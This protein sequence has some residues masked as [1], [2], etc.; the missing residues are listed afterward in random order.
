MIES[1]TAAERL[2]AVLQG[3][4]PDRVPFLLPVILQGARALG[5]TIRDYL[6]S[7]EAVIEG[8][9]RLQQRYGHDGVFGFLHAS[10]EVEAFGGTTLF[11]DDGPPNAGAPPLRSA[12]DLD[13]LQP[14]AIERCPTLQRVL[15]ILVGLR[16]RVGGRIPVFGVVISP[17][18]LPILQLGFEAYLLLLHEDPAR[19]ER[20]MR[21]NE[22]FA[23]AWGRAQLA[24]GADALTVVDPVGSPTI[25]PRETWL[26]TGFPIVCRTMAR[27][28]GPCCLSFA[29]GRSLPLIDDVVRTGAVGIVASAEEDLGAMKA[30]CRGRLTVVGNLNAVQMRHWS[31]GQAVEQTERALAAGAPGGGFVLSDNHGEIPWQVPDEVLLAISDTVQRMGGYPRPGEG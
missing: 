9:V 26:A 20:L 18:S 11:R 19:F 10:Q 21:V 4:L 24:A 8:Q 30:A 12:A 1:M 2:D 28:G 16:G 3:R 5:V 7:A 15:R 29:S 31:P 14:P 6:S 23:V 13:G 17:F 27:I 25:L 22:E